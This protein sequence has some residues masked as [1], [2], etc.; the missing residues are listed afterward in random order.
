MKSFLYLLLHLIAFIEKDN[1]YVTNLKTIIIYSLQ[2]LRPFRYQHNVIFLIDGKTIQKV[3]LFKNTLH[4]ALSKMI[5][6]K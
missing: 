5:P 1:N 6:K 2:P 4:K 3:I